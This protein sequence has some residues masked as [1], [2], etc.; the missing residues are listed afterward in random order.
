M[1][2]A[3]GKVA[4]ITG[5][6][7][8]VGLGMAQVFVKH[9]MKV[10]ITD[11]RQDGLDSALARL[12]SSSCVHAIRLDVTDRNAFAQAAEETERVFGKVH[13]VC[14][15]AGI[16]LFVPIEKCSYNDLDWI[17]GVNFGGVLNGCHTFIPY[18]RKHGEGGHIVNTASMS[19]YLP[20]SAAVIYTAAKA[21]VRG[22]SEALRL[23]LYRYN[24]GVSCFCPGMIRKSIFQ[25]ETIR[26]RHLASENVAGNGEATLR[27]RELSQQGMDPVEAGELVLAGIR[28]N[29]MYIFSHPEFK[30]EL[31]E[32]FAETLS[33]Q[34]EGETPE[35]RLAFENNRRE[36]LR[37][38]KA[39]ASG[40]G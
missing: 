39:A 5:G 33:Y 1:K 19:A 8:G 40:I 37:K 20:S 16:N 38:E 15:N 18:L 10:V 3:E 30:D 4:F 22:L 28:R 27:A 21:G 26:P 23:S 35:P 34:P 7:G 9:G 6:A 32:I 14:N 25:N 2:D 13:L 17:M 24:I 11:V 36:T 12:G 31:R 29:D